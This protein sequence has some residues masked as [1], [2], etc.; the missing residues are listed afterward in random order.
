MP[1]LFVKNYLRYAAATSSAAC[2]ILAAGRELHRREYASGIAWIRIPHGCSD[3]FPPADVPALSPYR[4]GDDHLARRNS[5]SVQP[6]PYRRQRRSKVMQRRFQQIS[7]ELFSLFLLEVNMPS[8]LSIITHYKIKAIFSR[9][10]SPAVR[11]PGA[12]SIAIIHKS[13]AAS[14]E[15]ASKSF[16]RC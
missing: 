13:K 7:K 15:A 10:P 3:V 5:H 8:R 1:G 11:Y 4:L 2:N 16:R 14:E 12:G 9:V 6:V